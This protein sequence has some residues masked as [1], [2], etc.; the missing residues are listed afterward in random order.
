MAVEKYYP[1]LKVRW[2]AGG[3]IQITKSLNLDWLRV[4][5]LEFERAG[6]FGKTRALEMVHR[7]TVRS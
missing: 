6:D 4:E 7:I 3:D 5:A 1:E 2:R